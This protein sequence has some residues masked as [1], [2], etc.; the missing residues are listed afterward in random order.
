M[1]SKWPER[2][3]KAGV[4]CGRVR[5]VP[6]A[7]AAEQV[8]AREA[9]VRLPHPSIP[10]FKVQEVVTRGQDKTIE[11]VADK[12]GVFPYYCQLHAAHIGGQ[13]EVRPKKE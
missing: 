5:S 10:D 13:L 6:E 3:G 9:V 12:P 8:R 7:L 1:V 2:L 4:P 11:F